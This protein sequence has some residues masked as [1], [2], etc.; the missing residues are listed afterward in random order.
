MPVNP[1]SGD[2]EVAGSKCPV[3]DRDSDEREPTLPNRKVK[4]PKEKD[5]DECCECSGSTNLKAGSSVNGYT[6]A[7]QDEADDLTVKVAG[8]HI[9]IRRFYLKSGYL[10]EYIAGGTDED[11]ISRTFVAVETAYS[12]SWLFDHGQKNKIEYSDET[13]RNLSYIDPSS[14]YYNPKRFN[15]RDYI[16]LGGVKYFYKEG[17]FR[18]KTSKILYRDSQFYWTSPDGG[19]KTFN[20]DGY[21]LRYGTEEGTIANLIYVDDKLTTI[22]DRY[23][24]TIYTYEYEDNKIT[25]TDYSGR[26]VVYDTTVFK[27]GFSERM[28]LNKVTTFPEGS[29]GNE[30]VT[31]YVY[32]EKKLL[33]SKTLPGDRTYKVAYND[34]GDTVRVE[35]AKGYGYSYKYGYADG[36]FS[37]TQAYDSGFEKHVTYTATGDPYVVTANE[38]VTLTFSGTDNT[39]MKVDSKGNVEEKLLDDLGNVIKRT[40]PDGST[41]EYRYQAD[42]NC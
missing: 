12:H 18:N 29:G 11:G 16:L 5:D 3:P 27:E 15:E 39:G 42:I 33:V 20:H 28:Q 31:T 14:S 8:G 2:G 4:W 24:Q 38:K 13:E 30:V 22:Q 6:G 21:L 36:L 7:Y 1:G 34:N 9:S 37:V 10:Y 35:D 41:I 25:I 17:A 19:W 23:E 40:Y 32:N 26:K